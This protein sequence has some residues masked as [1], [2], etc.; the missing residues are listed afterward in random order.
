[1]V[2]KRVNGAKSGSLRSSAC[3][4]QAMALNSPAFASVAVSFLSN[5]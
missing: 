2:S 1:M 3:R 4:T 5:D